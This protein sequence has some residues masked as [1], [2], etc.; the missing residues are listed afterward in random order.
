MIGFT[1]L[2][3]TVVF[4]EETPALVIIDQTLLPGRL[5]LLSLTKQ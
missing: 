3:D 1:H 4:D 2:P 5:E